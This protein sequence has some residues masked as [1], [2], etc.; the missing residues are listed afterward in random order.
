VDIIIAS[1]AK[2]F[3]SAIGVPPKEV[4]ERLHKAGI[5]VMKYVLVVAYLASTWPADLLP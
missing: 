4:I 1:K 2:L 3:V 5:V